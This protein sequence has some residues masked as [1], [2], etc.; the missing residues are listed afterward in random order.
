MTDLIPLTALGAVDARTARFGALTL[1]EDDSLGLASLTLR[2]GQAVPT[3]FGLTL[4]E[5]GGVTTSGP[6]GAFWTG[7]GQWMITGAGQGTGD[8]AAR[9]RAEA[10]DSSITEQTDG[11]AAIRI[12]SAAGPDLIPALMAKLVNLPPAAYA[13]GRATRTGLEHMTV[14]VLRPSDTQITVIGMRSYA[15][16]MWHAIS[17]A[18]ARLEHVPA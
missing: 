5:V 6:Y 10:P 1:A 11:F 16:S 17:V 7:A 4:P 12:T 18:A 14:F 13:S 2:K 3:P 9:V 8:F 15:A